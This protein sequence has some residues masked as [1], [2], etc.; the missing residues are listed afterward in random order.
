MSLNSKLS[1]VPAKSSTD[2]K[3]TVEVVKM[4]QMVPIGIDFWA[5]ARSPE[6]FEPAIMPV[7]D[8]KNIPM[9]IV[10]VVVISAIT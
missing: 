2:D 1:T 4:A 5:S 10:K 9:R 6:R 8:G 3:Y 7:T